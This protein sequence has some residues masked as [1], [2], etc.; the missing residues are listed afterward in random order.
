MSTQRD[1]ELALVAKEWWKLETMPE[2][3]LKE[4]ADI[5]IGK[6]VSLEVAALV[7]RNLTGHNALRA[8][9]EAELGI[10]P[11]QLTGPWAAALSSLVTFTVG[12]LIP[13]MAI[14]LPVSWAIWACAGSVLVGLALAGWI[15]AR[16]GGAPVLP[17]VVRN[18]GMGVLTMI[19]TCGVGALFGTT[20]GA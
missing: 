19:V 7:A 15:S 8:H 17:A 2:A 4:L 13:F 10:D 12:A 20:V 14:L 11:D 3:E 18:A 16:F 1:T 5:Y 6:G 9:S